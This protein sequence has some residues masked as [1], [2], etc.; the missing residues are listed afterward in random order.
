[1]KKMF[2]LEGKAA[3]ITGGAGGIGVAVAQ[4]FIDAGSIINTASMAAVVS[5][6]G[7]AVYSAAKRAVSQY[8]RDVSTGTW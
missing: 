1:M 2:S 6:I 3:F 7:S 4:R 5:K 8:D